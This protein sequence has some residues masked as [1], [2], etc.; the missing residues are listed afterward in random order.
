M[1]QIA[2]PLMTG[3][4][5]LGLSCSTV[6][7]IYVD[8]PVPNYQTNRWASAERAWASD[9]IVVA[10]F[11][12]A[13]IPLLSEDTRSSLTSPT[14]SA[15]EAHQLVVFEAA[16]QTL[17]DAVNAFPVTTATQGDLEPISSSVA[18]CAASVLGAM[19]C[20]IPLPRVSAT[21]D[22][23]IAFLWKV[24]QLR[25]D[26]VVQDATHLVWVQSDPR[27]FVDGGEIDLQQHSPAELWKS[28][29][30]ITA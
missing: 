6:A 30:H 22:G 9:L 10:D 8:E 24:G 20:D 4:V 11:G 28:V 13:A 18:A 27:G 2:Q 16:R 21:R 19:D 17:I 1:S 29:R 25:V 14:L 15:E 3:A 12:D 23:E 26:A 5:V 7:P